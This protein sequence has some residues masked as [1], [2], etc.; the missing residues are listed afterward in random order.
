M[1]VNFNLFSKQHQHHDVYIELVRARINVISTGGST[2][3]RL[4]FK[5]ILYSTLRHA[6][7]A[8]AEVC[9][10]CIELCKVFSVEG[11][12]ILADLTDCA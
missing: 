12:V 7:C 5:V 9:K 1:R 8:H 4:K 3:M 6:T 2:A 10:Q 11:C